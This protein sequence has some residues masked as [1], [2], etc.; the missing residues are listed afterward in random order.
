MKRPGNVL[1]SHTLARAVPSALEG[2][3]SEFEMGSGVAPP[4]SSPEKPWKH[5]AISGANWPPSLT[6]G[7]A[8]ASNLQVVHVVESWAGRGSCSQP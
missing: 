3:T 6:G 4:T 2:L 8:P 7:R 1:L 5:S